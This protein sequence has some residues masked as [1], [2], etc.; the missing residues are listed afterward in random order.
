MDLSM[1]ELVHELEVVGHCLSLSTISRAC[2][3]KTPFR[4]AENLRAFVLGC[5]LSQ[6][7]ATEWVRAWDRVRTAETA[8]QPEVTVDS[9][10]APPPAASNEGMAAAEPDEDDPDEVLGEITVQITRRHMRMAIG[11]LAVMGLVAAGGGT[12]AGKTIGT[13]ALAVAG[14]L[15][16]L[17]RGQALAQTTKRV[18]E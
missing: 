16:M 11:V 8:G 17:E 6:D 13:A 2:G 1:K 18:A 5:G 12:P 3:G 7:D 4:N 14:G 10:S 15:A 9:T